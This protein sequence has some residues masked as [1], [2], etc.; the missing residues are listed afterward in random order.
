[1]P[2]DVPSPLSAR[3]AVEAVA[4]GARTVR[5]LAEQALQAVAERDGPIGAFRV[6]DADLVRAQARALD[7][8]GA[9]ALRGVIVGVKDL[10]DTADLPTG[11]G[12]A[13]FA[14][15]QPDADADVVSRLRQAG[16]LVLG[17]TETTEFAMAA[18]ARTRNPHAPD[19]TPGGS[20]S[21]SAAA[22]AAG[23]VPVA[24][25]TQTAGSVVRPAAFCGVYGFKPSFGWASMRGVLELAPTLDTLGIFARHV[26][27]LSLL[28][29]A[30]ADD[31]SAPPGTSTSVEPPE[32]AGAADAAGPA[33]RDARSIGILAAAEWAVADLEAYD[34]L[35]DVGERL[36][37]A[38]WKVADLT[39]PGPW[40]GL[41]AHHE[42]L[43]ISQVARSLRRLLGQR[44]TEIREGTRALVA[45]GDA[46]SAVAYLDALAATEEARAAVAPL[47]ESFDLLLAPSAL[48]A[49]PA[50]LETTGDAVMCRAFS[51]LGLPACN[52][53]AWW[54]EDGLP[55][56]VQAVGLD[57]DDRAFLGHLAALSST[58][59]P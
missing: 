56:G 29:E 7:E 1:M 43:M 20:S 55:V 21:G 52:V 47:R 15:H 19:H 3:A 33:D 16:A 37:D 17:K 9:G 44:I 46:C 4:S 42:V 48:G 8:E 54:R 49:A 59:G 51:L 34:A 53:P 2:D 50:S 26:G 5:E 25:G 14:E 31:P 18:P 32:P 12:S 36:R 6:V 40:R 35:R 45:E 57:H 23:M 58:L 39:M 41:P 28:Y 13:I 38:G 24:L 10:I 22:V 11:Y 30:L 27:D